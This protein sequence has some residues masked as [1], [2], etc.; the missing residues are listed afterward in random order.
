MYLFAWFV[1]C[2]KLYL[3]RTIVHCSFRYDL[4]HPNEK[5]PYE[6]FHISSH[7]WAKIVCYVP[8]WRDLIL[9]TFGFVELLESYLWLNGALFIEF[10]P[11]PYTLSGVIWL[12]TL[13]R[14]LQIMIFLFTGVTLQASIFS[15]LLSLVQTILLK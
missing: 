3:I 14:K 4:Q 13:A 5:A 2:N 9:T 8:M 7:N 12:T 10:M 11:K 1:S 15:N 6:I